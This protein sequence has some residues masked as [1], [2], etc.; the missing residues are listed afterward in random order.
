[1]ETSTHCQ[2]CGELQNVVRGVR[3]SS[4]PI[5]PYNSLL[6]LLLNLEIVVIEGPGTRWRDCNLPCIPCAHMLP[7]SVKLLVLSRILLRGYS[8]EG[9]LSPDSVLESLTLKGVQDDVLVSD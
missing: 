2:S 9:I 7:A 8:L 1:M 6:C 3:Y 5:F 4:C